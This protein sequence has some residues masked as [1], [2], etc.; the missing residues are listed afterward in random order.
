MKK[1]LVATL[2][3]GVGMGVGAAQAAD[4]A[5]DNDKKRVSYFFGFQVAQQ[6]LSKGV[7]L[8]MAAFNLAFEDAK[9]EKMPRLT[10]EEIQGAMMRVEEE[11][12]KQDEL[13]SKTNVESGKT[14]LEANAKKE[15]VKT[16]GSGLQYK[17]L[18][19]GDGKKPAGTDEVLVHYRGTLIDG[20]EFD[21]S[22]KRGEPANF[23]VNG[24]IQ[25]WGEALMMMK[26]GDKWEIYVPSNLAYGPNRMGPKIGP[27]ATLVFEMELLKVLDLDYMYGSEQ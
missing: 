20:T 6:L 2:F 16:T 14:F 11:L 12:A 7:D 15:G 19:S 25:G 10:D 27:N 4:V 8:D 13:V 22:Y 3:A 23:P 21:N 1:F 5:L 9:A 18:K 24:V 26:E 17:V